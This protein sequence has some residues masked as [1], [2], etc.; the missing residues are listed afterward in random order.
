MQ[1]H[2]D[3]AM[4]KPIVIA[5]PM[6]V[7]LEPNPE[8]IPADWILE[9]T[10]TARSKML[11]RSH[12]WTSTLVVWEC[13][14][15]RFNWHFSQDEV[16]LVVSGETFLIGENGE[17]KRLG[18]GDVGYFPAGTTCTFRV[19]DRI[20]KVAVVRESMWRPLGFGLKVWKKLLRVAGLAGKSP[21]LLALAAL[22]VLNRG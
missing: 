20:R 1:E 18:P 3:N 6:A 8:P 2:A 10:P 21:L 15:G 9:S 14:A 13:T 5:N 19:P 11:A 12:D 22:T 4:S 16:I 17:E 7:G